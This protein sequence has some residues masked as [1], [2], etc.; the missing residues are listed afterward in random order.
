LTRFYLVLLFSADNYLILLS[1]A[2][3]L[4]RK[5]VCSLQWNHSLVP[6]TI[7]SHLRLCSLFVAS[8]DA[9]G[10]RWRYSNP[11]PHGDDSYDHACRRSTVLVTPIR[12]LYIEF[13]ESELDFSKCCVS[14]NGNKRNRLLKWKEPLSGTAVRIC[15]W[16]VYRLSNGNWVFF[17]VGTAPSITQSVVISIALWEAGMCTG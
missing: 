5:R 16:S 7:L 2:S 13:V 3:S 1:K 8:Y 10:L 17:R 12:L 15:P 9:Q 4:T 6:I 14:I 11:P